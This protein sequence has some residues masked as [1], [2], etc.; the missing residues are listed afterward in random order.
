MDCW[1]FLRDNNRK[2]S[3]KF[4]VVIISAM[5]YCTV[6]TFCDRETLETIEESKA[7]DCWH[8]ILSWTKGCSGKN[9]RGCDD[10]HPRRSSES[11]S[12]VCAYY[13]TFI[14]SWFTALVQKWKT[15]PYGKGESVTQRLTN[16]C[17]DLKKKKTFLWRRIK[18][19]EQDE[20]SGWMIQPKGDPRLLIVKC[21][22][23]S[24]VEDVCGNARL[25]KPSPLPCHSHAF[26]ALHFASSFL[27]RQF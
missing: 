25:C 9:T 15:P 2:K 16:L 4:R 3:K 12:H 26:L 13:C 19:F 24:P 18:P 5:H 20:Q 21:K 22:R 1:W 14:Y 23:R 11:E 27:P 10:P 8:L 7:L 6:S 17:D